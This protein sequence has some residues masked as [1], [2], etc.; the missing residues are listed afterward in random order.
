MYA[1]EA[2]KKELLRL[3]EEEYKTFASKLIPKSENMLGVR[4]PDLR[5]MAKKIASED[6]DSYLSNAL[7]DTFEEIM[8]QG[9]VI[10]ACKAEAQTK[11]CYIERFAPKIDNWSVCDSFCC[12]LKFIN[13]NRETVWEFIQPY[14]R[15]DR[16]YFVRLG[17]VVMIY[18]FTDDEY[19]DK[20]FTLTDSISHEG[21]YAK[22]AVAW[23]ISECAA[24][25]G[26][27]TVKY[28]KECRLDDFTFK[29]AIQKSTES[30]RVD[31]E[32]KAQLRQIRKNR[33]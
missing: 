11:L 19:T 4:L 29:R 32:I 27:K 33:A 24:K 31:A 23:L 12:G 14:L 3:C 8:L 18:Y 26:D 2:I 9:M 15:S 16:E 25:Y 1:N 10:G 6:Y 17:V 7:D 5:K 21:Y 20:I 13:E 30:Y 28:L 22:T